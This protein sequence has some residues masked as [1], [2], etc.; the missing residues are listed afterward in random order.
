MRIDIF[1]SMDPNGLRVP[2]TINIIHVDDATSNDGELLYMLTFNVGA[3]DLNGNKIKTIII[4]DITYG[5]IKKEIAN[6]LTQLAEQIDWGVLREDKYPPVI[7]ELSPTPN[8]TTV[9]LHSLVKLKLRDEFPATGIN[10]T[11]V[12]LYANGVDITSDTIIK[13]EDNEARITW[14]PKV[15]S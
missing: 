1:N 7:K 12:K 3:L 9:P 2:A 14:Y 15:I 8:Q 4:K 11:S 10:P 6:G 5:N 13:I